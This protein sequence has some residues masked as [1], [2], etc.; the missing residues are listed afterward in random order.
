[1]LKP[2]KHVTGRLKQKAVASSRE[3]MKTKPRPA[4]SFGSSSGMR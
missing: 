2:K 4:R 1:M 3:R